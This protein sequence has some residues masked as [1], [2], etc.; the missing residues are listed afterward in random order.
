MAAN[1]WESTQRRYWQFS[2]S[3]LAERRH[4][5]EEDQNAVLAYPLPQ[6]RHLSIYFNQRAGNCPSSGRQPLTC[7]FSPRD[8]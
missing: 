7:L 8:K 6:L 5:L 2:R 4:K 3:E 1:Y